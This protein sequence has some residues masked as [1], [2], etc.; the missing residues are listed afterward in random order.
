MSESTQ[1]RMNCL[2]YAVI[3]SAALLMFV[4]GLIGL[5]LGGQ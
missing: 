1:G 5:I 3:I 2:D 4:A